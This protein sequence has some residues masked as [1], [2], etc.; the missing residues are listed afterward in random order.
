LMGEAKRAD[1]VQVTNEINRTY[2]HRFNR[3]RYR[4][5][6]HWP[7]NDLPREK[8]LN[9]TNALHVSSTTGIYHEYRWQFHLPLN[10]MTGNSF[11]SSMD[12]VA[13]KVEVLLRDR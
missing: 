12:I 3:W 8:S 5:Q 10:I 13:N 1:V 6:L 7:L 9:H 2:F 4:W 11:N